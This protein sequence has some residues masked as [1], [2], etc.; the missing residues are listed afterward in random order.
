MSQE[1]KLAP[2]AAL[3]LG[4][5]FCGSAASAGEPPKNAYGQLDR[6]PARETPTLTA[7][8]VSKLK[9]DLAGARDHQNSRLKTKEAAPQQKK[10]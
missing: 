4:L 10:P 2:L 6:P 5:S 9:K 7:D 3:M 8:E 1:R